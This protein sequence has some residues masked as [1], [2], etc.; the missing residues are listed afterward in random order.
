M[1]EQRDRPVFLLSPAMVEA[2]A[3]IVCDWFPFDGERLG[4]SHAE[5]RLL[6]EKVLEAA[7]GHA[8]L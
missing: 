3:T 4:V 5:A 1:S 7:L 2:G 6:T 8:E